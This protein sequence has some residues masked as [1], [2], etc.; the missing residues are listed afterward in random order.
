MNQKLSSIFRAA[1]IKYLKPVD[2]PNQG[3]NQH[4]IGGLVKSGFGQL[5]GLPQGKEKLE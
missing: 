1:L 5:L 2:C 4:E 3:S